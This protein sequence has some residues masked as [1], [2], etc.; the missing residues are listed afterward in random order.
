MKYRIACRLVLLWLFIATL[1]V[2]PNV[3]GWW[4]AGHRIVGLIAYERMSP[5]AR[6]N[7]LN[8]LKQHPNWHDD[9]IAEMPASIADA[10]DGTKGRWIFSQAAIW[11][12]L[13]RPSTSPNNPNRNKSHRGEW[14]YVNLPLFLSDDDRQALEGSI[15]ANISDELPQ[16]SLASLLEKKHLN[17][18]QALQ[19]CKKV[20]DSADTTAKQK[21]VAICWLFH[22]VGDVHQPLH[23]TALFTQHLFEAGDQGG[24][25]I[26]TVQRG[27]LHKFWD[28]LL[29]DSITFNHARLRA[30]ELL[31]QEDLAELAQQAAQNLDFE[32]WAKESL[33]E[34]K[35]SAYIDEVR[36]AI[37]ASE[38]AQG[39]LSTVNLSLDYRK[40][41]GRV[42]V[43]R[44]L[45]GGCRLAAVL[46]AIGE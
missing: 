46:T 23:G 9:F 30:V 3:L 32:A 16:A 33:D 11:P 40:N 1:V 18:L 27:S 43:R 4:D 7:T 13:V 38:E 29:G 41:A 10:D 15:E 19:L 6:L 42:A 35:A 17:V 37:I 24:N 20:A 14:H 25:L 39:H 45:Q 5:A 26:K 21:A 34:A 22:L 2:P 28:G 36:D 12:D 31:H 8:L 44:V